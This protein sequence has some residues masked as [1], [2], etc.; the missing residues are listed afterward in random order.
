MKKSII[1]SLFVLLSLSGF[2][3]ITVNLVV[4]PTPPGTLSEWSYHKEA[5]AYLVNYKQ[6][7]I[8]QVK[9]KTEI[10]LTD[11]TAVATTNLATTRVVTLADGNNLFYAADVLPLETMLF[12]GKF[13]TT[14]QSTGKLPANNYQI[15]VTLVNPVDYTPV[16]EQRCRIFYLAALQLPIAMMPASETVL[17]SAQAQTAIT[18]RWT[19]VS[20]R[21]SAP[22]VYHVQVFQVLPGQKSMQAFRSNQPVL[23]KAVTGTTQYIWQPQISM[24]AF[25]QTTDSSANNNGLTF[26]WTIR[27]TDAAGNPLGDGSINGDGRS[28]P[29]IF[30]ISNK[31][32]VEKNSSNQKQGNTFGE[33][34]NAGKTS[35]NSL[36]ET[37]NETEKMLLADHT[38][39]EA[40][41]HTA[42][43]HIKNIKSSITEIQA[44]LDNGAIPEAQN[45]SA[46]MN[47][48]FRVFRKSLKTLG[49]QYNSVSNVLKTKHDTVKNSINNV[50]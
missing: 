41:I 46:A 50:R 20:P 45:K 21:P 9:I 12:N 27:A 42:N 40:G 13:K 37:I 6:G 3:Q 8:R 16:S 44:D 26:I 28:E 7:A 38:S 34:V 30:Y 15:C 4:S 18:F 32:A 29:V 25:Q 24:L 43:N 31:S 48:E 22:V 49:K 2:S 33:K 19:P 47:D 36:L 10:K 1:I 17:Q 5:L 11:G 39:S 23:D 14:L 35:L